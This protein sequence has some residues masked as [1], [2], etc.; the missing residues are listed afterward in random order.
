MLRWKSPLRYRMRTLLMGVTL[1]CLLLTAVPFEARQY[2]QFKA[3]SRHLIVSRG[4]SAEI[5]GY[6]S[7]SSP[8][9]N[10][11][12]EPLGYTEPRESLWKVNLAGTSVTAGDLK[13][14]SNCGWIISLDLSNTNVD[15]AALQSVG[16][17][18]N[19]RELRLRNTPVS[20]AGLLELKPLSRLRILDVAGATATYRSLAK[21]EQTIPAANFQEQLA[22][23]RARAA[24]MVI[25]LGTVWLRAVG[26]SSDAILAS[27]KR[28]LDELDFSSAEPDAAGSIHVTQP[29]Q[30]RKQH[31]EDL[32][33]LTSAR[34][35]HARGVA[36]PA[37]LKFLTELGNLES[38]TIDD[39]TTGNLTDEDLRW[40][41]K[42]PRL[43]SLELRS[44]NLTDAGIS[45]LAKSPQLVALTLAGDQFTDAGFAHLAPM[46]RLASLSVQG[47]RLT[48]KLVVHLRGLRRLRQLELDLWSGE[49][50][51]QPSD[52]P[53]EDD[54]AAARDA[55]KYYAEI[56]NLKHL[57]VYGNLMIA[58]VLE[59]L[60]ELSSLEWLKVDGRF[61]SHP[62]ARHL[63]VSMRH[64]H[65]QR[66]DVE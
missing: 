41:A 65:V 42:L 25:D 14:L 36:F 39:G 47:E 40:L 38:V 53:P 34:A 30:L 52:R 16:R 50:D 13:K 58:A 48:P 27:I 54:V 20:D 35:F 28:D 24:G 59:P 23:A 9:K 7:Q 44:A 31:L 49:S 57:S 11:L 29:I 22:V 12:S 51:D 43:K 8:G 64:C 5:A 4:G 1:S 62:E 55:M 56:P 17:L 21:L 60:T 3:R 10:W 2:H 37:G 19:L 45:H 33:R 26:T 32:R 66:V 46:H 15:D 6:R 61:V 18:E 63:Q